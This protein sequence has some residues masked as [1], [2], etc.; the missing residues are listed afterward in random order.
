MPGL[1][2]RTKL[3]PEIARRHMSGGVE[4]RFK[5]DAYTPET[6][7]MER[8]AEYLGQLA[9]L[10]GEKDAVHFVRIEPGS[11]VPVIRVEREAAPKVKE[12]TVAVRRGS[13]PVEAMRAY[14]AINKR[15]RDDNGTGSL[16][17]E[18]GAE[19]I[20]FPGKDEELKPLP[21]IT[22]S[23]SVDGVIIRIGGKGEN[24]PL[25]LESGTETISNCIVSRNLAKS[26]AR[27]IFEPVRLFGHGRWFRN[28][29]G[30]WTLEAF[31]VLRF[32]ALSDRPLGNIIDD[33]RSVPAGDWSNDPFDDLQEIRYGLE[34]AQ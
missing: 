34:D 17:D 26:L 2:S 22:Q 33:L 20:P 29:D 24:V 7:P 1:V 15:L 21:A 32:E 31:R 4:F 14:R 11:V 12:R 8:L 27:R 18:G 28:E 30:I 9:V 25:L 5:L 19:I 3:K 23:G 6:I 10:L 16:R 13:G